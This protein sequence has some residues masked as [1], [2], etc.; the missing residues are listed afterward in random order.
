MILLLEPQ[1]WSCSDSSINRSTEKSAAI[2]IINELFVVDGSS[3][4]NLKICS[5]RNH[6]QHF[7]QKT[8]TCSEL[9]I[10][11][12]Q[13]EKHHQNSKKINCHFY[14]NTETSS[15]QLQLRKQTGFIP[16]ASGA[17][18]EYFTSL[19]TE[20]SSRSEMY[21]INKKHLSS[22]IKSLIV[23]KMINQTIRWQEEETLSV[24][25]L[26]YQMIEML[27]S[28]SRRQQAAAL[29]QPVCFYR[30]MSSHR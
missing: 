17:K 26:K 16:T 5:L 9:F 25:H 30:S 14:K 13:T 2:L 3:F 7:T 12:T 27:V 10:G 29:Q 8:E 21:L 15:L 20:L 23:S 1:M 6:D 24:L 28:V 4:S 11:P 22:K 19:K 18:S